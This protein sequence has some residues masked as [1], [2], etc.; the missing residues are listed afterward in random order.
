[1]PE[2]G[3]LLNPKRLVHR[4]PHQ[5][6]MGRP[7]LSE[8]IGSFVNPCQS[9]LAAGATTSLSRKQVRKYRSS[10]N[11]NTPRNDGY[12]GIALGHCVHWLRCADTLVNGQSLGSLSTEDGT[13][14]KTALR[15]Y[16]GR[17]PAHGQVRYR[18][19]RCVQ[20]C[21]LYDTSFQSLTLGAVVVTSDFSR[22][23]ELVYLLS[24]FVGLVSGDKY[25]LV[26]YDSIAGCMCIFATLNATR[27]ASHLLIPSGNG[28]PV[29]SS[30]K[31]M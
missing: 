14:S 10:S 8:Q 24:R 1:M 16:F 23:T 22:V 31:S 3:S 2:L 18:G 19:W 28:V 5:K 4:T 29:M 11:V 13:V 12:S 7:S 20:D 30:T 17:W 26:I 21:Y 6:L 27:D 9:V 15:W 25:R